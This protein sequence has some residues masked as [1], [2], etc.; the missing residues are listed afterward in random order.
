MPFQLPFLGLIHL[1]GAPENA[2]AHGVLIDNMNNFVH[3]FMLILAVGWG[4]FFFYCLYRFHHTRNP[5]AD[6]YGVRTH[7]ST[8]LELGV[9]VTEV[10]LLLG[11]AFPL[12]AERVNDYPVH[13]NDVVYVR[14][15][16]EQ[17][18]WKFHYPGPDGKFGATRPEMIGQTSDIGLDPNDPASADDYFVQN[19]MTIPVNQPVVMQITSRDVIHNF[20]LHSMRMAQDA[21]P[22]MEI[23]MWFE[24]I[25][26]GEYE[27]VCGQLCGANHYSMKA[28]VN[29][30]SKE[31]WT[32]FQQGKPSALYPGQLNTAQ[33]AVPG[34]EP[35]S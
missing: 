1:L 13:R 26:I 16:G 8:H 5:K 24:P 2:S 27:A 18:L 33:L 6:Y 29:V 35:Q 14:V 23:N 19:T 4:T 32:K 22:G 7:L 12:W 31:D 21:I 9:I 11:F 25:T 28:V 34:T 3:W 15:I 20:A 30:V 17:F 10:M